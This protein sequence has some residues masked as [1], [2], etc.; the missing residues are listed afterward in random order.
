MTDF[1]EE[2]QQT[3]VKTILLAIHAEVAK[4]RMT[5]ESSDSESDGEGEGENQTEEKSYQ[6]HDC[7]KTFHDRFA[8]VAHAIEVHKAPPNMEIDSYGRAKTKSP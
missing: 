2:L 3:D 8:L 7:G 4:L 1:D 6:C 5:V